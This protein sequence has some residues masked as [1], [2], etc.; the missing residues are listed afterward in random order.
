MVGDEPL[1][2][3]FGY[4]LDESDPDIVVLRRQDSS[5]AAAFSAQGTMREDIVEAAKDD[6]WKLIEANACGGYGRKEEVLTAPDQALTSSFCP[7]S[8]PTNGGRNRSNARRGGC[9]FLTRTRGSRT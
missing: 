4:Y 7:F 1:V 5:F 8:G 6:S 3:K 9:I 2:P